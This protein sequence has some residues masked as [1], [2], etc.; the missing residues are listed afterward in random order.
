MAAGAAGTA[1]LGGVLLAVRDDALWA[2]APAMTVS[3]VA[4]FLPPPRRWALIAV[5]MAAAA[6]PGVVAGG[7]DP[8]RAVLF[9]PGL[10]AFS[11]WVTLGLL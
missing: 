9:P 6:V 5:A 11:A 4:T 3:V 2:L 10:V 7:D 8:V 1:T